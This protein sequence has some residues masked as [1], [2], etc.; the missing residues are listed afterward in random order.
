[1]VSVELSSKK[2]YDELKVCR[3]PYCALT[4]AVASLVEVGTGMLS[5]LPGSVL[6]SLLLSEHPTINE[7]TDRARR[8]L[9]RS[10]FIA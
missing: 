3:G 5:V 1:V 8:P 4:S 6:G 10:F 9:K 2:L 7:D